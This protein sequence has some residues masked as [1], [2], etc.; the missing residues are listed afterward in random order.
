MDETTQAQSGYSFAVSGK[1]LTTDQITV[2]DNGDLL[3]DGYAA[4]WEGDD[5]EGENFAPGA[6]E[7]ASKAFL[8][9]GGPLCFHH[10]RDHVMGSVLDLKED[11]VGLRF[12]AR[13][14]GETQKDPKL[15]TIY[16]Q[17]KKGT[18]R[19]VSVGGFFKRAIIEGKRK[20]ADMDFTEISVTGVPMHTGPSFA[21]VSGKALME[22]IKETI[23]A[24][25]EELANEEIRDSDAEQI[26]FLVE[27]L[28]ALFGRI[29]EGVALRS[30]E[31]K[32]T[33]SAVEAETT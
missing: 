31:N 26:S 7:R 1:A 12:K 32:P 30:S 9:A 23:P 5:R 3:I 28:N 25:P 10:K 4:V 33:Q 14:D 20:I 13:V 27:E 24:A 15:A 2:E 8:A 22:E 17:I 19:G 18:I 16:H 11:D 29:T 6:F 21:V